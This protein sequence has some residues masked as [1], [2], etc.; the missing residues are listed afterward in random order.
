MNLNALETQVFSP[1]DGL[2]EVNKT[3]ELLF[4]LIDSKI[5]E[6]KIKEEI[7]KIQNFYY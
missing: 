3:K 6:K 2:N 1:N 5:S 7:K 4:N